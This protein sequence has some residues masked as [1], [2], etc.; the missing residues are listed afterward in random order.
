L[1][2][3]RDK[4]VS[5]VLKSHVFHNGVQR[6]TTELNIALRTLVSGRILQ[7]VFVYTTFAVSTHAF[8][9]GMSVSVHSFAKPAC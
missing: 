6:F 9:D 1:L 3:I 8:I 5:D 2:E 4:P 7:K